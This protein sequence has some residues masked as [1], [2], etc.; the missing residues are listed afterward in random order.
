MNNKDEMI[1]K[2]KAEHAMIILEIMDGLGF[3]IKYYFTGEKN[4]R[5]NMNM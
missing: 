3:I 5:K 1:N 4:I 2:D